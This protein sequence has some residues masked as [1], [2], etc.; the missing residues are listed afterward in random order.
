MHLSSL[1]PDEPFA[2]GA[3]QP[4]AV[5]DGSSRPARACCSVV[6]EQFDARVVT[7]AMGDGAGRLAIARRQLAVRALAE[8]ELDG[9]RVARR[10][11]LMQRRPTP[12]WLHIDIC[13]ILLD[14][15]THLGKL[16]TLCKVEEQVLVGDGGRHAMMESTYM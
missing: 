11:R 3:L 9:V 14:E 1:P 2:A 13:D 6:V 4:L 10:A 5:G 15:L 8:H 12:G 7:V 16:V